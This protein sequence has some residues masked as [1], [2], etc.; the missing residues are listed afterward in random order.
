MSTTVENF[1]QTYEDRRTHRSGK[2]LEFNE[3]F[4]TYLLES[5]DGKTF[6]I[7]S[8]QFKNN[9]RMIEQEEV[10]EIVEPEVE[11]VETR[12]PT[13][14]GPTEEQKKELDD[15]LANAL[16]LGSNYADSFDNEVVTAKVEPNKRIFRIKVKSTVVFDMTILLHKHLCRVWLDEYDNKRIS[17]TNKPISV[18]KYP[19]IRRCYA[20]EFEANKL[21]EVLEDLKPIVIDKMVEIEGGL[22]D[23]TI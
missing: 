12:E 23:G 16:L 2:L 11:E 20:S 1:G 5:S 3:K 8:A 4:K 6:N 17:W 10:Q 7:T 19:D 9:W 13:Y 22:T 21:P 18:K 14:T 15:F